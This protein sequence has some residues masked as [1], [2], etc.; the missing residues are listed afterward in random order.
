MKTYDAVVIGA[1]LGGLSAAARLARA[2]FSVRLLERHVQPGGYATTFFRDPFEFEV[3]L[4]ELCD[5][6]PPE[7]RGSL[8]RSL[9]E[10]GVAERVEFL[11]LPI[12]YRTVAPGLD[13]RVPVGREPALQ[14]LISAFPGERRGLRRLWD[15]LFGI[16]DELRQLNAR[17]GAASA[18]HRVLSTLLRY[19]RLAHAATVPLAAILDR[20]LEDPWARLAVTQLWTYFGLPPS[21]LS[22]LLFAGG[23]ACYLETGA[24]YPVG[25][26]QRL[27][28]AFVE[29]I[30]EAGGE[31]SLGCG[32]KQI[33][34]RA[35]RV[36]GVVTDH[37][38]ELATDAVVANANPITTAFDLIGRD[39]VP[40]AFLHR[41]AAARPSLSTVC[42]Y[43]GLSKSSEEL[44]LVD[45]EV[46]LNHHVDVEKQY[47][48]AFEAA[49]PD[50]LLITAYNATDPA[51]SPPGTS[52]VALTV[53]ADGERWAAVP[54]SEYPEL[55][56]TL[57]E[58][59]VSRAT[60]LYPGLRDSIQ[61]CVASTPVTNM[62]YTGNVGGAIYGFANTPAENPAFRLDQR[63]PLGGL[64][65][66]GAWTR[67]GGGY[68]PCVA[69]G[70]AAAEAI[71]AER[72][73]ALPVAA[74]QG[75]R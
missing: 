70:C 64:W 69:S 40:E 73:A 22:L 10:L 54:A 62:R 46:F 20:A 75:A 74:S 56:R 57:A 66:A 42:V 9:E 65:F 48:S 60:E 61:V 32:A 8:Y 14:A 33:L 15:Q 2:G 3:S 49:L 52:V 28:N 39:L 63:G 51:F 21:Q 4:H 7:R 31:V 72:G 30:E 27:S 58:R 11:Q 41:L 38:E 6:G 19:P 5:I 17:Q 25:K 26:S 50:P 47:A 43:L 37:G 45:H 53:L 36:I 12:L 23:L 71:L 34:C 24:S 35:G 67:P 1:G 29:V 16:V 18:P 13:L 68:A 44:G 59:M 55:K